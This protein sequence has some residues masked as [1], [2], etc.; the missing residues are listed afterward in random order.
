MLIRRARNECQWAGH[1][2][3]GGFSSMHTKVWLMHS[4]PENK[5]V[6]NVSV[7]LSP[8]YVLSNHTFSPSLSLQH[9]NLTANILIKG[10]FG[11]VSCYCFG[12]TSL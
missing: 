4:L 7:I 3:M 1:M 5:Y 9:S 12:K 11:F 8:S 10:S 2:R 6:Y